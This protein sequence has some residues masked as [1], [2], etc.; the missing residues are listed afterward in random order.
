M[1]NLWL[2]FHSQAYKQIEMFQPEP[3]H[4]VR[5]IWWRTHSI[6]KLVG[7]LKE[8][9]PMSFHPY[10]HEEEFKYDLSPH[11]G[12]RWEILA[13]ADTLA[14]FLSPIRAVLF[15]R[16]STTFTKKDMELGRIVLSLY[17]HSRPSPFP[18]FFSEEPSFRV[19]KD[20]DR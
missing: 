17:P 11:K 6:E 10:E 1:F 3:Y 8:N 20:A 16:V 2:V 4:Y 18:W 13:K 7:S 12:L 19:E 5:F 15:Q 9:F 14:A